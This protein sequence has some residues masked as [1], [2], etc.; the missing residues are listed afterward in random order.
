MVV[1][2]GCCAEATRLASLFL[3]DQA[4]SARRIAAA[5]EESLTVL[6]TC[7]CFYLCGQTLAE[8]GSKVRPPEGGTTHDSSTADRD[9][10]C[11]A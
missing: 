4:S 10:A 5:A 7:K 11:A 8:G 3:S 1:M 9:G 2:P 6:T